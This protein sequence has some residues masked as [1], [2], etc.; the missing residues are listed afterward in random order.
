LRV[1]NEYIADKHGIHSAFLMSGTLR[2]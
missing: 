1:T 2:T